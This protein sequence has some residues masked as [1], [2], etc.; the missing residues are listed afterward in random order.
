MDLTSTEIRPILE[1]ATVAAR[2]AGQRAMEEMK[3]TTTSIK[4]D[5]TMVT[6]ADRKCQKIIMD[7]IKEQYPDH[8]FIAE[9]GKPSTPLI[10][11]PRGDEDIW[12]VIDPI[13]GTN[14]YAQ[15]MMTFTVSIAAFKE[16]TPI[17]AAI[18][19]PATDSMFT[20]SKNADAQLNMSR[21]NVSDKQIDRF[22]SFGIDS[23]FKPEMAPLI[24][25]L[26]QKTRFRNLGSTALHLAYVA[27][28]AMI[29]T[30]TTVAKLWDIAA[31]TLLIENAGGNVTDLKGNNIFPLKDMQ[32]AASQSYHTLATNK[33]VHQDFLK[34]IGE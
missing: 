3:F 17:V 14:N 15:G 13:D 34:I 32:T 29:G 12:W 20:T 28:G 33:K 18:Y 9:E 8:G 1:L 25:N 22:S 21:I 31:G 5:D 10:Q 16:N 23:H 19:E 30:I 7:H 11:P 27:K 2:L 26:M 24:M 4:T 6:E